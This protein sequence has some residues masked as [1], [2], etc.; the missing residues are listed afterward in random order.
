MHHDGLVV[1]IAKRYLPLCDRAS[2]FDDLMQAGRIGVLLA[3]STWDAEKGPFPPWAALHIQQEMQ[4][5]LGLRGTRSKAQREAVSLDAPLNGQEETALVDVMY[6]LLKDPERAFLERDG[7]EYVRRTVRSCVQTLPQ[8]QA[9][10]LTIVDLDGVPAAQAAD[11]L[12]LAPE[13]LQNARQNGK[14][15]LRNMPQLRR[16]AGEMNLFPPSSC[17][18]SDFTGKALILAR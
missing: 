7:T 3:A 10:A 6:S 13:K 16:L 14:R 1:K 18:I 8:E 4:N 11:F 15:R 5:A 2:D 17:R 12:R 9:E